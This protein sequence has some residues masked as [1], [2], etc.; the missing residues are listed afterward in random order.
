MASEST[1]E[2][3]SVDVEGQFFPSR[4]PTAAPFC[5]EKERYAA[6]SHRWGAEIRRLTTETATLGQ[7]MQEIP[8]A[9]LPKTF[10][11]A[12]TV[13]RALGIEYLWIDSLC[14]IQDD[15]KNWEKEALRMADIYSNSVVTISA[16]DAEDAT[17]GFLIPR[18]NLASQPT[19]L[20]DTR[21]WTFQERLLAPRTL[22]YTAAELVFECQADIWAAIVDNYTSR[23]LTYD[24]DRLP[25][26]AGVATA[27]QP[28]SLEDYYVG[29]WSQQLKWSLLRRVPREAT[30]RR[31]QQPGYAPTWSWASASNDQQLDHLRRAQDY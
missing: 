22:H 8:F 7:R 31:H 3:A 18:D 19:R 2:L 15:S 21:G 23:A 29:M 6:L 1:F 11:D 10:R 26:I 17:E 12:V 27:M 4:R 13:C 5:G 14:I 9:D 30:S 28:H 25:A 16:D 24:K 20:L